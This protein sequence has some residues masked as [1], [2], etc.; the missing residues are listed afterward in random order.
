MKPQGLAICNLC[1]SRGVIKREEKIVRRL[2]ILFLVSGRLVCQA[3]GTPQAPLALIPPR[4]EDRVPF[5]RHV[6]DGSDSPFGLDYVFVVDGL[7][8]RTFDKLWPAAGKLRL[9]LTE[10]PIFLEPSGP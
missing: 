8:T 4:P 2:T 9:A 6:Q 1:Q 5:Q 7:K 10:F 3:G